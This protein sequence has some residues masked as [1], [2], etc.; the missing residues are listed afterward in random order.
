MDLGTRHRA[1][2]GVSEVS[3]AYVIVVSEETGNI[4]L[5]KE[6]VL[7][8]NITGDTLKNMLMESERFARKKMN[9]AGGK[10]E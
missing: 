6:G 8:R 7:Y 2:L 10:N 9:K 5:C 3:D 4:S 1:G